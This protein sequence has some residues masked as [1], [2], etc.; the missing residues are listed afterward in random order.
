M[1]GTKKKIISKY[2]K[3]C[4]SNFYDCFLTIPS[5]CI[6]RATTVNFTGTPFLDTETGTS[7]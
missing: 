5:P 2:L 4:N 7:V 6:L 3:S 1:E